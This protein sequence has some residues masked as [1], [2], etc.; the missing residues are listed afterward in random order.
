MSKTDKELAVDIANAYI[1]AWFSRP[2]VKTPLD[3]ATIDAIVSAS[4]SAVHSLPAD[5]PKLK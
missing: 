2:D 4:Y 5:D 3:K 1:T